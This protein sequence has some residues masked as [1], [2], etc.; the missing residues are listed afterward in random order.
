MANKYM[1]TCS[2][3]LVTREMHVKM[4]MTCHYKP[5]GMGVMKSQTIP[6]VDK[7]VEKWEMS[8]I[9]VEMKIVHLLWITF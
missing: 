6:S 7:G 4:T 8:C 9:L 2:T 3:S 5:T 1:K